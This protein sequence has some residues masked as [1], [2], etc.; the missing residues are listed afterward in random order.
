[1]TAQEQET[2]ERSA[3]VPDQ[4][5]H[6][7]ESA[8][9]TTPAEKQH[10]DPVPAEGEGEPRPL[11][12]T[13]GPT[14]LIGAELAAAGGVGVWHV[15][16][17]S[18]LAVAA[19]TAAGGTWWVAH[20]WWANRQGRTPGHLNRS[21]SNGSRRGRSAG[22]GRRSGLPGLGG[23]R[24]GSGSSAGRGK[25][26]SLLGGRRG[27][28]ATSGKGSASKGP[29]LGKGTG[30]GR[31][32]AGRSTG[33][34]L[35]K[36]ASAVARKAS[37]KRAAATKAGR[38]AGAKAATGAS[39]VRRAALAAHGAA[40]K[41]ASM[42]AVGQAART[43]AG[44]SQALGPGGR[45]RRWSAAAG[46]TLLGWLWSAGYRGGRRIGVAARRRFG[47]QEEEPESTRPRIETTVNQP[48]TPAPA[49]S[50][51]T[52][53]RMGAT[54]MNSGIPDFVHKANDLADSLRRY[55]PGEE[56]GAMMVFFSDMT[57][58]PE[59]LEAMAKGWEA[60]ARHCEEDLPL[61]RHIAELIATLAKVQRQMAVDGA[62]IKS[63]VMR[64]H[65]DD[66]K[67]HEE[68]RRNEHKWNAP[69]TGRRY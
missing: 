46:W 39:A 56:D 51:S 49:A 59:A 31:T 41:G 66:L 64:L 33:R 15:A 28:S 34:G 8:E 37:A 3:A 68:P 1:M 61:N 62:D 58:I 2:E 18:G 55:D 32:S 53:D 29:A 19:V 57:Y 38:T 7:P 12:I 21:T 30:R 63:A 60:M 14:V 65:A 27:R 69:R 25:G 17:L 11:R 26:G 13:V 24:R 16:G 4:P 35:P 20:R 44:R 50:A 67:R 45:A 40:R 23:G 48:A 9:P 47:R 42:R 6:R 22:T 10:T 52:N 54:S 5:P 43:A 36:L